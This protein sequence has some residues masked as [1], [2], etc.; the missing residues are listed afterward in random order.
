MLYWDVYHHAGMWRPRVVL[1]IHNLDNTGECR[2]VRFVLEAV[3]R[4]GVGWGGRLEV[5]RK[6]CCCCCCFP[7]R[8]GRCRAYHQSLTPPLPPPSLL[9]D[10]QNHRQDEFAY[11]GV[12][13]E[14]FA[15]VEKALDERTIGHNPEARRRAAAAGC[16][17]G[18]CA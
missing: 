18:G 10:Q 14:L 17:C 13:G 1:T 3:G 8:C 15:T 9:T 4:G 7:R 12:H 5:G 6:C 16:G 2:Q 11:T